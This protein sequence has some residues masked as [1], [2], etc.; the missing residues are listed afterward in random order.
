VTGTSNLTYGQGPTGPVVTLS[1]DLLPATDAAYSL[2]STGQ[3]FKDVFVGTGSLHI[4]NVTLSAI[5]DS[6]IF[7]GNLIPSQTNAFSLGSSTSLLKS[8]HIGPGTVFIGPTGTI[9]NDLNG[10]IYTQYGFAAPSLVLGATIP[11]ISGTVNPLIGNGVRISLT[12]PTG[13]IQYQYLSPSGLA[14]GPVYSISTTDNTGP[15][16]PTGPSI[17]YLAGNDPY[18]VS[19]TLI[20]TTIGTTQTR[21]YQIGP[22]TLSGKCLV[23]ANACFIADRHGVQLTVGRATASGAAAAS[24]TNIVSNA[25]PLALPVTSPSYYMAAL[26][27]QNDTNSSTNISGFALDS[28]GAGTYYYTVWMSSTAS[29]NYTGLAIALTVLSV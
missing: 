12:G 11:D 24:S 26:A 18:V 4:G 21:M 10:I 5:D 19:G 8:M 27:T 6:I 3:R 7:N 9:G 2:G 25:S 23:M 17:S 22:V 14:T 29:H 20:T 15:A 28:P 16:G 13:P 1:G